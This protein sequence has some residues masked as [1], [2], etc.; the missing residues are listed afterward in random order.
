MEYTI[1]AYQVSPGCDDLLYFSHTLEDCQQ[2]A[3]EQR[4]DLKRDEEY[5][6]H[7]G[8][9]AVYRCRLKVPSA[10][11]MVEVMNAPDDDHAL[12]NACIVERQ[13]VAVVA[14]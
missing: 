11:I 1:F 14:E 5:Q 10:E 4:R 7:L 12:F 2:A 6:D 13:L 3:I 9:M 8:A